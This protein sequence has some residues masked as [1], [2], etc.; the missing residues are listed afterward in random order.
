[1]GDD[2]EEEWKRVKDVLREL[3]K[4]SV[5]FSDNSSILIQLLSSLTTSYS[6]LFILIFYIFTTSL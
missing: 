2:D 1:M 4:Y 3:S 5:I 6:T